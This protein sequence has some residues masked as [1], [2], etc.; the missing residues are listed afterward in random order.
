MEFNAALRDS[1]MRNIGNSMTRYVRLMDCVIDTVEDVRL[2]HE[3]QVILRGSLMLID[4]KIVGLWNDMCH[5]IFTCHLEPLEDLN[6]EL[7]EHLVVAEVPEDKSFYIP[8]NA[9]RLFLDFSFK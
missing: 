8:R 7:A 4:K 6:N 1:A 5:L 3:S 2:L 9:K